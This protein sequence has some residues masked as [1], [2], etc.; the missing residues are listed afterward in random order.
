MYNVLLIVQIIAV[1]VCMMCTLLLFFQRETKL[2][3]LMLVTVICGLMQNFGY[4][5]EMT[6][7]NLE[8]AMTAIK[9]EYIGGSF[10]ALMLTLFIFT[11]SEVKMPKF[12][13][14]T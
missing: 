8:E 12:F 4:L 11:Y 9:I 2:T 1:I 10:V 7:K 3:K 5:F 6:A 14:V 13:W